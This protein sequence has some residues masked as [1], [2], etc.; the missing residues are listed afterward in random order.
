LS[1]QLKQAIL[2]VNWNE[3]VAEFC[4]HDVTVAKVHAAIAKVAVIGHQIEAIEAANDAL[5][6]IREMQRAGHDVA[7]CVALSLYK[8]AAAAMRS[9]LE[10]AMYYTYFRA[11]PIELR[12]LIRDDKFYVSKGDVIEFYTRHIPGWSKRQAAIGLVSRLDKWYKRVSAIVHGQ[13]P[14]DWSDADSV[15]GTKHS[16]ALL[17][18]VAESIEECGDIVRD[19]LICAFVHEAW[20]CFDADAKR[21]LLSGT[22]AGYR[23]SLKL[24]KA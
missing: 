10:C 16:D 13:I 3:R 14:G 15:S 4:S 20:A 12:T 24:D 1:A 19:L 7:R 11:H 23:T 18:Q 22:P 5:P 6:F 8:P 21:I 9:M 2:A 17:S